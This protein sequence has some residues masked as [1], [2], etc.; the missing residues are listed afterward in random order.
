MPDRNTVALIN[1]AVTKLAVQV[2]GALG[3]ISRDM[4]QFDRWMTAETLRRQVLEEMLFENK[5]FSAKG[6]KDE[7]EERFKKRLDAWKE[8][9]EKKAEELKAEAEKQAEEEKS[10]PKIYKPGEV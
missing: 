4:V 8:E 3:Q 9:Q 7:F 6:I 1:Q 10:K 5:D 2:Q